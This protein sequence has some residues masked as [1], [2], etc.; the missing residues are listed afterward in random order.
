MD[1]IG[2]YLKDV[3]SEPQVGGNFYIEGISLSGKGNGFGTEGT[4][5]LYPDVSFTLKI[6]QKNQQSSSENQTENNSSNT[7]PPINTNGEIKSQNSR[8]K[9]S[10]KLTGTSVITNENSSLSADELVQKAPENNSRNGSLSNL[11]TGNVILSF[12]G[13]A[14]GKIT[15]NAVA[16]GNMDGHTS[17]DNPFEY[18]L[19]NENLSIEILPESVKTASGKLPDDAVSLEIIDGNAI[20]ATNYS[21]TSKG[22]GADFFG[23]DEKVINIDISSLNFTP[24]SENVIVRILHNGE[25][26][27]SVSGNL[28]AKSETLNETHEENI[29]INETNETIIEN[30]TN[31]TITPVLMLTD[32][33]RKVLLDKFENASVEI[34]KA[35]KNDKGFVVRQ[36]MG[37]F[38]LENL[39]DESLSE[40]ALNK[41]VEVDRILWLKDIAGN[42]L[43]N[44]T[45]AEKLDN[46]I[47]SYEI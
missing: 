32:E 4:K 41:A 47:G 23:G 43:E 45:P 17:K 19:D 37:G 1:G 18:T 16:E 34:T 36:E 22:F 5:T 26:I 28:A 3:V 20:I 38:W 40:D 27:L 31:I 29:T 39:Y 46:L 7:P 42:L 14:F 33:E 24:E 6:T 9:G 12:L 2:E 30:V 11:L 8:V 15:G 44:K 35:E 25:E 10:V 13:N 21:E